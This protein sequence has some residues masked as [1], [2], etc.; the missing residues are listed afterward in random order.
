MFYKEEKNGTV[1]YKSTV[2]DGVRHGFST[3]LGGVSSGPAAGLNMGYERGDSEE[4]VN[5]NR[6]IFAAACGIPEGSFAG[7]H[8]FASAKQIHSCR[9]EYV[10]A[11]TAAGDFACDGFV[12]DRAGVPLAVKSAD[13]VPILL[14]DGGAG[15]AAAVH[16][17]WRGTAGGIASVAVARMCTLGAEPQRIRAAIGP[18]VCGGCFAVGEDF[19]EQFSAL[20]ESSPDEIT[21]EHSARL[22]D[23]FIVRG[24]DGR[25]HCDLCSVNARLLSLAGVSPSHIDRA[26][27]C[28]K[29][30]KDEFWSHRRDGDA[31][32]VMAA[33]IML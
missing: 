29:E 22:A 7:M 2:L 25:L 4:N 12:T 11:E 23:E 3:R 5:E 1:I 33:A 13:C 31:R 20:S 24:A 16:A 6:R 8:V 30:H 32:G 17:G 9:V 19:A 10:T 27:I 15:V 21:R 18:A 14:Y 26:D 28:T